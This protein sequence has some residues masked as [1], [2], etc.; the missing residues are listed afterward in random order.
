LPVPS[1]SVARASPERVAGA[2]QVG[3]HNIY[4]IYDNCP[5]SRRFLERTG[6]TMYDLSKVRKTPGWPR[7]WPNFSLL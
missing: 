3:P 6:L 7:S 4:N 5:R 2:A 1:S